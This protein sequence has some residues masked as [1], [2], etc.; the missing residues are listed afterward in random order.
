MPL[1]YPNS[2]KS[3]RNSSEPWRHAARPLDSIMHR[4]AGDAVSMLAL[5]LRLEI[6]TTH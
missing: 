6:V 5:E 1:G 4:V 3:G 2:L